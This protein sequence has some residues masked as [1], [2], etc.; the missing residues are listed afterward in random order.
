MKSHKRRLYD[1]CYESLNF[2]LDSN[3]DKIELLEKKFP[4]KGR[5]ISKLFM[6]AEDCVVKAGNEDKNII[7]LRVYEAEVYAGIRKMKNILK[8]QNK[9]R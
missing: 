6:D 9:R 3:R 4:E 2:F 7:V 8:S 5:L 1:R